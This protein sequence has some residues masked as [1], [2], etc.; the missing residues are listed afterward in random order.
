MANLARGQ[1]RGKR[2]ELIEALT[3]GIE[4]HHRFLL[5]MQLGRIEAIETDMPPSTRGSANDCCPMA[6]RW[7]C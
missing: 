4:E 1:L 6:P 2:A 7:P 3:G 5:A